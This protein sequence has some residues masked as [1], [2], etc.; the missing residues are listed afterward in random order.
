MTDKAQLEILIIDD[1]K[2]DREAI[3]RALKGLGYGERA[4]IHDADSG[5]GGLEF[6][7]RRN[8][9]CVFLDYRLP[10]MDGL[11]LLKQLYDPKTDL[12]KSPIV[13]LTGQGSEAVMLEALRWGA[14]DYLLKD[15]ITP[16]ALNIALK[17]A[18]ELFE[19][20]QNRRLAEEQLH[21]MRKLEAVGQLTS[22]IA[23][24]FNNLLT[25]VLGNLHL[26]KEKVEAKPDK[27]DPEYVLKKIHTMETVA[28]NG[29]D[30]IKRL[31]VFT[32]QR[33][34]QHQVVNV[35]DC[36]RNALEILK[37]SLGE[38]IE[39]EMKPAKEP[40]PVLIDPEEFG[41]VLINM[42][43]NA[44]DAMPKGGR[45][46][47]ATQNMAIEASRE[48]KAGNYTLVT[49]SDTGTGMTPEVAQRIF[50]PF[51][52]TKPAGE[53]TG[54][55]LSMA[56]GFVKQSNGHISVES[57]ENAG[58]TFRIYL[59]RAETSPEAKTAPAHGRREKNAG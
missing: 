43:V 18:Q 2:V 57:R 9:D 15:N 55:G 42:A 16:A 20:K 35:N 47:I 7:A 48:I 46:T 40:W 6:I 33:P 38:T 5:R 39:I 30:L 34:L 26:L 29:A 59:P 37:R 56:Y 27:I 21:H 53:G 41:N 31:M 45:L 50:E 12:A 49:V 4:V 44:R 51:F 54:L 58:T 19:L 1:N 10:D 13:M 24:D 14:Q 22:G 36:I 23:H 52:T 32:R 8:V 25:V 28:R 3:R 11:A 17:K